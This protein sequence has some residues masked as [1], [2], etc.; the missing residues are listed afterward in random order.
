MSD[1]IRRSLEEAGRRPVPEPDPAFADALGAR[2]R[3][4]AAGLPP[5]APEPPHRRLPAFGRRPF[6]LGVAIVTAA[7]AV[8]VLVVGSRPPADPRLTAPVNVEVALAGG[9]TLEDPD[10]LR[11]PEG[12]VIRVGEGG[13]ARIG[14]VLLG[15]GDVATITNGRLEVEHP[16][17]GALPGPAASRSPRPSAVPGA[18][19]RPPET[20]ASRSTPTPAPVPS[21]TPAP[22]RAPAT[23]AG[24]SSPSTVTPSPSPTPTPA[25]V[26]P[27]LRARLI[28]GPRVAVTWTETWRASSY[29]LIASG[30]R[31]GPAPDP[32]YPGSR[33]L[34]TYAAPP[35]DPLRFRVP[36]GTVELR[37]RVIALRRDGSVL[38]RSNIVTVAVPQTGGG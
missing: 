16:T 31:L 25:I 20:P 21:L 6:G 2:L 35:T 12:A 15:P 14:D 29:V 11:L 26:R 10:G 32:V 38:R 3:V 27:R 1:D 4:V 28:D 7:I 13:S 37:L 36:D 34:G 9:A 22:T 19:P 18:T 5:A 23:P 24:S 17:A 30:S 8:A 33:I